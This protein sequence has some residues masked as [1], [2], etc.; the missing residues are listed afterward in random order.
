MRLITRGDFDGLVCAV[1]LKQ[2]EK[3][4]SILLV[5]PREA[6][7]QRI[8]AG[9]KDIV[10]NL[11]YIRGC[12]MWF[13]HHVS[14]K[15]EMSEQTAVGENVR[16]AFELAPS[17]AEVIRSYYEKSKGVIFPAYSELID[18]AGRLDSANLLMDDILWPRHW[19]LLGMT[20]DPR[21]G[22]GAGFE[23]YFHWLLEY[24]EIAPLRDILQHA[25]VVERTDRLMS[26][27]LEFS[28]LLKKHARQ[29]GNV[30]VTDFRG[31]KFKPAGNRFLVYA[32][33]PDANVE[34][35]IFDGRN[36]TVVVSVGRSITNRTCFAN[37]GQGLKHYGGGGHTGAGAAQFSAAEADAKIAEIVD[38]LKHHDKRPAALKWC[39]ENVKRSSRVTLSVYC[40]RKA[41]EMD[42]GIELQFGKKTTR[43]SLQKVRVSFENRAEIQSAK[44]VWLSEMS[45]LAA[46]Y[47]K[48]LRRNR[49]KCTLKK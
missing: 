9:P 25:R 23:E 28:D 24:I 22:L 14:Q 41:A 48:H 38:W 18:A 2:V 47:A 3:I 7:D 34:V 12:G 46:L 11:P 36:G 33:F 37:I 19:I 16:G 39:R 27:Q 31:V 44:R 45:E 49:I 26:E 8:A 40:K 32:L 20:L 4:S 15:E 13:D 21:S 42:F 5:H 29:D 30:I 35:R 17:C 43:L 1:L 10:A 6:Q